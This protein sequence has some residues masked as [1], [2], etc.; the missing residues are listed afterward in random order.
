MANT[1]PKI[2]QTFADLVAL[3]RTAYSAMQALQNTVDQLQHLAPSMTLDEHVALALPLRHT[4]EQ[5]EALKASLTTA[6]IKV[7]EMFAM[8]I[9]E[10]EGDVKM[11]RGGYQY[12]ARAKCF[13]SAPS[14]R[15]APEEFAEFIAWMEAQGYAANIDIDLKGIYRVE[16]LSK[17]CESLLE[18]AK[19]LPPHVKCHMVDAIRVKKVDDDAL[20]EAQDGDDEDA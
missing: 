12:A 2:R 20:Q 9:A 15:Q 14:Q 19:P 4:R 6:T 18:D 17:I 13:A 11:E 1:R 16:G 5:A 8:K 3:A 10:E 7:D